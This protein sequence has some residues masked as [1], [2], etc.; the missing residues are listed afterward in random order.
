VISGEALGV[1]E[2]VGKE[3]VGQHITKIFPESGRRAIERSP[4]SV[5]KTGRVDGERRG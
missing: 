3:G 5:E 1:D 2:R 4:D